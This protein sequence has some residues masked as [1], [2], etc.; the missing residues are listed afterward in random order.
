MTRVLNAEDIGKRL[1][2]F[3][4]VFKTQEEVATAIGIDR[5]MLSR[6]ENGQTTPSSETVARLAA[7]YGTTTDHIFFG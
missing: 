7:Y 3:R 6:Y 2:E 5:A 4:G 1:R